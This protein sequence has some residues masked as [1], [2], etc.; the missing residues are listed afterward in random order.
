[1]LPSSEKL[2]KS[3]RGVPLSNPSQL[4]K[5]QLSSLFRKT[6]LVSTPNSAGARS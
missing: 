1:M 6:F 5:P 2:Y 4:P 3:S